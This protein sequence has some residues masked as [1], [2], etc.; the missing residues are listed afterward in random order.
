MRK[1]IVSELMSLD[2]VIQAPGGKDED[3][4][5]GFEHGGWTIPYST[6]RRAARGLAGLSWP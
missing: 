5:D 1:L 4:D 3:R 6:S 2:G